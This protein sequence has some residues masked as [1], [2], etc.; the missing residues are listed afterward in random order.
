MGEINQSLF[1]GF[2]INNINYNAKLIYSSLLKIKTRNLDNHDFC[3]QFNFQSLDCSNLKKV[4]EFISCESAIKLSSISSSINL[5][6]QIIK[7][8][9]EQVLNNCNNNY[10]RDSLLNMLSFL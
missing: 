5:D 7:K 1:Y 4:V 3:N 8:S 9:I 10:I 6:N 2:N